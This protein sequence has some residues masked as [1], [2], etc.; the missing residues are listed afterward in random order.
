MANASSNFSSLISRR[1]FREPATLVLSPTLIKLLSGVI[2]SGSRPE[3]L[4]YLSEFLVII[5]LSLF[6]LVDIS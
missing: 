6:V 1:N 3:S 5:Q 2:I 4:M